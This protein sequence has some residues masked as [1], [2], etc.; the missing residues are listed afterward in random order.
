MPRLIV[1]DNTVSLMIPAAAVVE[2]VF[3]DAIGSG[4][5]DMNVTLSL[6]PAHSPQS[7][8]IASIVATNLG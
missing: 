7:T 1:G 6:P 3:N 8:G 4:I 5:R 2:L